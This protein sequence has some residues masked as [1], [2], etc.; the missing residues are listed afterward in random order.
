MK[1][2]KPD[3]EGNCFMR[4]SRILG[5]FFILLIIIGL[6]NLYQNKKSEMQQRA[7]LARELGLDPKIYSRDRYF[8]AN[9]FYDVLQPGMSIDQVHQTMRGYSAVHTCGKIF[10]LYYFFSTSDEDAVRIAIFY[11]RNEDVSQKKLV[12]VR[13]EDD[14]SRTLNFVSCT[15][16]LLEEK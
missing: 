8:P 1:M 12:R 16:G 14:D 13:T 10:E 3:K 5:V 4:T 9:Y 11:D 2:D 6:C 7:N 15:P